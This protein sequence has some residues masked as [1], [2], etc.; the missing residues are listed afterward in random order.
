MDPEVW[1]WIWL[2]TAATFI[3]G[4]IAT[5]AFF[6]LPF[7]VGAAA[8]AAVAFG[9]ANATWQWL[10]FLLVSVAAFAAIQTMARRTSRTRPVGAD[11]LVGEPGVVVTV[12]TC[13]GEWCEALVSGVEGWV[14]QSEIWGAYP[15]EAFK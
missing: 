9:G 1:R 3:I 8:A 7:G 15:G 2:A 11:R 13:N 4:E 6:L 14:L 12:K 5:A 10:A